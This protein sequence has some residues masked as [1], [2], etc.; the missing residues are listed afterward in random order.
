M[1]AGRMT[2][3]EYAEAVAARLGVFAAG[4]LGIPA[5]LH[6]L[7]QTQYCPPEM[8]GPMAASW[9]TLIVMPVLYFGLL[10]SLLGISV[11]RLRDIG[12]PVALA[13]AIPVLMLGDL[14]AALTLDGFVFDSYVRHSVHPIPAN[15]MMALACI[16][17]LCVARSEHANDE[18]LDRRWGIAGVVAFGVV[19]LATVLALFKFLSEVAFAAGSGNTIYI[20]AL[21]YGGALLALLPMIMMFLLLLWRDREPGLI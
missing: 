9:T 5:S 4:V 18:A 11:R 3:A 7:N 12:L 1:F 2:R 17:F 21:G 16:G 13:I 15:I 10:L 14:L 6:A 8:C 20:Y 19:T